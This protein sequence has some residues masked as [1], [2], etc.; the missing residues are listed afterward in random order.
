M[1]FAVS[2]AGPFVDNQTDELKAWYPS[3]R[4][5]QIE[6]GVFEIGLVLA[7]AVSAGSYT[8]GV[9]DFLVEALDSWEAEKQKGTDPNIPKHKVRLRVISGASA[10][11]INGGLLAAICRSEFPHG[12]REDNPLYKAWVNDVEIKNL[13]ST[14]DLRGRDQ[15]ISILNSQSFNQIADNAIDYRGRD[16]L[17]PWLAEGFHLWLTVTNVDGVPFSMKFAAGAK[18]GHEMHLHQDHVGFHVPGVVATATLPDTLFSIPPRPD[19]IHL[20]PR[21]STKDP[22]WKT[23]GTASLAT[24]AFPLAFEHQEMDR[25]PYDYEYRFHDLSSEDAIMHAVPWPD[26][27]HPGPRYQLKSV[28]GGTM[29]N[30]PFEIARKF[31]SGTKERNPRDGDKANR[32]I[33]MV[34]PFS[35]VSKVKKSG[36]IILL[37]IA[38]RLL[39]AFKNQARF[40]PEDLARAHASNIYSRFL[41]APSRWGKEDMRYEGD[42]A[43][44]TGGMN[45]FFGLLDPSFRDHDFV[46]G[47]MNCRAF[48]RDW[49]VLPYDPAKPKDANNPI[50]A[51]GLWS[52]VSLTDGSD[53]A[54]HKTD[55]P[56]HFQI[57]PVMKPLRGDEELPDWPVGKFGG[58][59]SIEA[60]VKNRVSS[61]YKLLREEMIGANGDD[62]GLG[63]RFKRSLGRMY[64]RGGW[65]IGAK[66]LLLDWIKGGVEDAVDD[67]ESRPSGNKANPGPS[68]GG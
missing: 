50:F 40:K 52:D 34:D 12:A 16:K 14:D 33:I 66:K 6:P 68:T 51:D 62:D 2:K 63:T 19:C 17:R 9:I 49:F 59:S 20:T 11:G 56:Q 53:Y 1:D 60:D 27:K 47:R 38:S 4:K 10:G 8:A 37:D 26:G 42:A 23:L 31:L 22:G 25:N 44:A 46:L 39:S 28:D 57:I 54:G 55:R 48:L 65:L 43:L 36:G 3:D 13:L 5:D 61:V 21:S 24:A 41:V 58:F 35:D 15:P 45:G 29:N 32:A 18:L 67:L 7:G 30:E 64:I